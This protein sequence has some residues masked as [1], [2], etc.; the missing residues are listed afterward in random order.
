MSKWYAVQDKD[1]SL[2][3]SDSYTLSL[4]KNECGWNT[5]S[6]YGGYGLPKKL[7]EW[8]CKTLNNSKVECPYEMTEYG[9][10]RK[11]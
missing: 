1:A 9:D 10:W 3:D 11:K 4:D 2:K 6:G 7:A 5:D 8:I